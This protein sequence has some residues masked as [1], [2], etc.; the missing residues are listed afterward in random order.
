MLYT[1]GVLSP[2]SSHLH[3]PKEAGTLLRWKDHTLDVMSGQH[4]LMQM[5]VMLTNGRRANEVGFSSGGVE[6]LFGGLR[7]RQICLSP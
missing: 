6:T 3:G 1:P 2:R 7:V 5:K 4:A